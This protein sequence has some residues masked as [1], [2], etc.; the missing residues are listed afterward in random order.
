VKQRPGT[1]KGFVFMSVSDET[2][3]FNVISNA[4]FIS[5]EGPLQNED[6]T[7]HVKASRI[8]PLPTRGLEV[9]SHD[10]H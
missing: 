10:F 6:G 2:D 4:K 7:I 3:I 8:M 1:A 5:V 9:T